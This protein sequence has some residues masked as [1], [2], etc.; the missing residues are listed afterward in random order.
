[1]NKFTIKD[2]ENLS[3][4]KAHTIRIWE[5]RYSF[6]KPQRTATNIRYYSNQE[7]KTLLN[8]SL[9]NKYGFK[10]S[11][12]NKMNHEELREKTLTLSNSQAQQERMVNELIQHM[13]DLD[14][15]S[16]EQVLNNFIAQRGIEKAITYIIFPFLERIGVLWLTDHINPAQEHLITN[17]IRQKIIVGIENAA[18]PFKLQTKVL[19]FMPEN[20]HHE[21][22]LLFLQYMLKNRGIQTIYL[23]ANV[24]INDLQFIVD[25]KKPDHIYTHLTTVMK[26]FNFEKF[27]N[28]LKNRLPSTSI[29]MSGQA[30]QRFE[31]KVAAPNIRF[32]KSLQEVNEFITSLK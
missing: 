16:L 7:L 20:E 30:A 27:F 14:M 28:N 29:L 12:I 6:L 5:Q 21:L 23:G 3:G 17:I 4:I 9:L 31:K 8:I 15:E 11:H 26:E 13:I 19:L 25:L 1:M 22:G 10:V 18:A 24:P 2:L 32:L